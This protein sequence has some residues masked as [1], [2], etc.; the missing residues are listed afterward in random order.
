MAEQW[1]PLLASA[2]L[3]RL[4]HGRVETN[5]KYLYYFHPYPGF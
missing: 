4:M 2:L 1:Q 3:Y 5:G